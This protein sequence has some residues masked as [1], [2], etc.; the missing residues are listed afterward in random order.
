MQRPARSNGM[1]DF[2]DGKNDRL[3]LRSADRPSDFK[4][5]RI[6]AFVSGI[7]TRAACAAA[8]LTCRKKSLLRFP[9]SN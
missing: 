6:S 9:N 8:L 5:L 1:F 7:K 4:S 3:L 2:R